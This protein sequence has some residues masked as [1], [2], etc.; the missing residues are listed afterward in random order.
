MPSWGR[1][2]GRRVRLTRVIFDLSGPGIA[3]CPLASRNAS[4]SALHFGPVFGSV[5][6]LANAA[7]IRVNTPPPK[8]GGFRLRLKAGFG[9]PFGG[10]RLP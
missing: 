4:E 2:V 7:L 8:G 9:P 6:L 1:G 10:L 3:A 5:S